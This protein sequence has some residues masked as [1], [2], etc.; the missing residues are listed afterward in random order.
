MNES[1][2]QL[3]ADLVKDWNKF[4]G[5]KTKLSQFAEDIAEITRKVI[6]DHLTYLKKQSVDVE[7]ETTASMKILGMAIAVD[8]VIDATYP[9]VKGSVVLK[10]G[11][12]TR[13]IVINPNFSI[14]A[15]GNLFR[16]DELLKG[17][18]DAFALNAAEFVRD[19][20][21]NVARTGG[22]SQ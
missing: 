21:L 8:P 5:E 3:L 16:I 7:C 13:A 20:F 11:A 1:A 9:N 12:A 6:L 2:R 17:M 10:C 19:G 15:G 14:S 22:K 18:P 4:M